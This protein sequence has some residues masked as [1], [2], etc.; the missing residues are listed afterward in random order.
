ML[1]YYA[2]ANET[3]QKSKLNY[4]FNFFNIILKINPMRATFGVIVIIIPLKI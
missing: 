4:N 2:T 3:F 1:W